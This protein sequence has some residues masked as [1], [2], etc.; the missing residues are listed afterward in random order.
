MLLE[1][2]GKLAEAEPLSRRAIAIDEKAYGPDH[3]EVATDLNN[4]AHLLQRTNRADEAAPLFA[5]AKAIRKAHAQRN[6]LPYDEGD[7]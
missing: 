6:N 3:P 2:Q 1:G 4:L 7:A 5:R